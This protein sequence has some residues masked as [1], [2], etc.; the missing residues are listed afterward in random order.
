MKFLSLNLGSK[1]FNFADKTKWASDDGKSYKLLN[2]DFEKD[3][4][5]ATAEIKEVKA[6]NAGEKLWISGLANA[7]I[8]D[9]MVERL[10]PRGIIVNDYMKNRQLLA[11]HSYYHPIGQVEELDIQEDGVHFRAW[12]GDPARAELTDMQKEIRS[13]VAQGI[14]K[15]VSVGFIPKKVRAPLYNNDGSIQEAAVIE[16][17]DLLELSVVAIPCNQDSVFEI[18]SNEENTTK[19]GEDVKVKVN[20]KTVETTE[21]A[22]ATD[23]KQDVIGEEMVTLL[24]SMAEMLK[25]QAEVSDLILAKLEQEA[26]GDSS[27]EGGETP[28]PQQDAEKSSGEVNTDETATKILEIEEMVKGLNSKFDL[29]SKTVKLLA[30]HISKN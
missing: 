29:L 6:I 30:S 18:R 17:W 27:D 22:E 13:L 4:Q 23:T 5:F 12:I 8:V 10:D 1:G 14:L 25:R 19:Q 2:P 11:H 28:A 3:R 7:N 16:S 21:A 9:R 20:G 26:G 24:R 15:T